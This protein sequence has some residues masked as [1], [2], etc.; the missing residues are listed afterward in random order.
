MKKIYLVLLLSSFSFAAPEKPKAPSLPL[1]PRYQH[2]EDG[3]GRILLTR[4]NKEKTVKYEVDPKIVVDQLLITM[5]NLGAA[6][7]KKIQEISE[8][9]K[10]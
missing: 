10:K 8:T 2:L 7:Q 6:C 1:P 3:D 4:D 9:K 5:D